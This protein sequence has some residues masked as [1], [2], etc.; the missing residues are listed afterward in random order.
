MVH[1]CAYA[2]ERVKQIPNKDPKLLKLDGEGRSIN[3][4]LA[5]E[6]IEFSFLIVF[7]TLRVAGLEPARL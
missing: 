2:R 5:K 1:K 7:I 6:I 4:L 3:I